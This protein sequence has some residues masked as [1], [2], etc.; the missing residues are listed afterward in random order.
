M[1]R[2]SFIAL[3]LTTLLAGC[4][5]KSTP[6]TSSGDDVGEGDPTGDPGDGA[7]TT[8]PVAAVEARD[9][10]VEEGASW[11]RVEPG[12]WEFSPFGSK[13]S[14][15]SLSAEAGGRGILVV[16]LPE[17]ATGGTLTKVSA[18]YTHAGTARWVVYPAAGKDG[19]LSGDVLGQAEITVT[20]DQVSKVGT[21]A[22]WTDV[23]FDPPIE[24]DGTRFHL[25]F[26]VVSGQPAVASDSDKSDRVYYQGPKDKKPKKTPFSAHVRVVLGDMH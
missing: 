4:G 19:D 1:L 26:E 15:R 11:K 16:D 23:T 7:D 9:G 5:G 10:A 25:A 12:T 22:I 3:S 2:S 21:E 17:G 18:H 14:T 6:P 20:D 8:E 24:I 13:P